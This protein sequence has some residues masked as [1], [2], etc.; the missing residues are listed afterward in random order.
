ME[1]YAH[2]VPTKPETEWELLQDHSEAVAVRAA[3]FAQAF[4]GQK[5]ASILGLA[6]DLG[7]TK[8]RFQDKLRGQK[9][10]E[11]HSAEGAKLLRERYPAGMGALLAPC[12]AGHHSGLTDAADLRHRLNNNKT[13]IALPDWLDLPPVI[14]PFG[15][16]ATNPNLFSIQF[17]VRMLFSCLVDADEQETA[18]FYDPSISRIPDTVTEAHQTA[19]DIHMRQFEGKEGPVNALRARILSTVR[20]RA[21]QPPGLF[22]LTVPTGGGKT[23]ASLGFALD[24]ARAHGM[25]R[26]IHVIPFTSIVEQTADVFSEALGAEAVVEHHSSFDWDNVNDDE[27]QKRLYRVTRN[28]DA[29]VIV[30]TAVQFFESLFAAR[31]RRCVKLHNLAKSVIV[32]DEAQTMPRHLL[33][34]CLAAIRELVTHYGASVVL[35]TATQPAVTKAAGLDAPEALENVRELAPDPPALYR[36]LRRTRVVDAGPMDDDALAGRIAAAEQ[37][38]AI[39]GTRRHARKL[40]ERIE[41]LPGAAHLSTVMT[42]AHRRHVLADVR[43]RLEVREPVRL[44]STSLVEAG[45]DVDFPLV[46]RAIAGLDSIAQAA[47]RC[48]REGRGQGLGK[49]LVFTPTAEDAKS[50]DEVQAM[51]EI[52]RTVM[53][54]HSDDPLTAAAIADY[55]E[56]FLWQ[57]GPEALDAALVGEEKHRGIMAEINNTGND[58]AFRYKS[59]ADAFRMINDG[60]A[61]IIIRG[62]RWGIGD[63]LLE[64][65][66]W[67][68]GAGGIAQALQSYTI[69]LPHHTRREL[70]THR[71][72]SVWREDLFGREFLLLDHGTL[73]DERAGLRMDRFEE[74]EGI[75]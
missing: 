74:F 32:I 39:V 41:D 6:H 66:E 2:S 20:E 58:F 9:N 1:I 12:V 4:E 22:S 11:T 8:P 38:L 45:V 46:M 27:E 62:G 24:H 19:F 7:K 63:D 25:E 48:N 52:A 34:P 75:A 37:V 47:G 30:T 35:S 5:V 23:L 16:L 57:V 72:A 44:V 13:E 40:F 65:L 28:W 50:S 17:A 3:L 64:K 61:P 53:A 55:F 18:A 15:P 36:E 14:A 59:I 29:P 26:T 43:A 33:R 54:T 69:T 71:A 31:K 73:Y 42:A 10:D 56:R 68:D 49:V 51:A 21:S 70:E 60:Q 67:R